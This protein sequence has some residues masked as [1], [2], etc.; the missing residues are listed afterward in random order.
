MKAFGFLVNLFAVI[1]LSNAVLLHL[2]SSIPTALAVALDI[3]SLILFLKMN[4]SPRKYTYKSKRLRLLAGGRDLLVVFLVCVTLDVV[5]FTL[6][7]VNDSFKL[8]QYILH[9]VTAF[10]VCALIFINGIV[11]AYLTS[12][13]LGIK[14]RVLGALFGFVPIVNIAFLFIIIKTVHKELIYEAN[15]EMLE[16]Q[17]KG[18]NICRTRYPILLVHGVFF[19]DSRVLNYWGRVPKVLQNN[20]AVIYYGNQQSALSVEKSAAELADRIREIVEESGCEKVNIIAHSKGGLDSRYAISKLGAD[21]Y[22][23]SLTTVNTPHRGCIFVENL[24][25]AIPEAARLKMAQVYNAASRKIGDTDPDFLSA[26]GDL[27]ESACSD[28]NG[29]VENAE[30]VYYQSIGS[31]SKTAKS[32][33]FPLD[34][35]YHF[36]KKTDGDNDGLVSVDSMKWGESFQYIES[37]GRRGITHADVIDLNRENIEGFDVREFYVNVV[38]GLR[39]KGL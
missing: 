11:R 6:S 23:A 13:Q 2:D 19:R 3:P 24:F 14:L 12:V 16:E 21:R 30:G 4:I 38:S 33:R 29:Q 8:W 32:G 25:N 39:E 20:G 7:L 28:F 9:V 31:K 34:V 18:R 27:R 10:I 26:V 17:R 22:V 5:I 37:P 15:H 36:V 35:S 1:I